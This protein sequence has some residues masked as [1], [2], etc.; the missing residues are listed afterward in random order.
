ML[1]VLGKVGLALNMAFTPVATFDEDIEN[2]RSFDQFSG[3]HQEL[4]ST[5]TSLKG[6]L[7]RRKTSAETAFT[8]AANELERFIA[9]NNS[10]EDQKNLVLQNKIAEMSDSLL[11]YLDRKAKH[12][13]EI[14]DSVNK[15][16]VYLDSKGVVEHPCNVDAT[17]VDFANPR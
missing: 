6:H 7:G 15:A 5:C 8:N 2:L 11:E 9:K 10:P 14:A 13:Q 4:I 16:G 1:G 3:S 17:F 12:L